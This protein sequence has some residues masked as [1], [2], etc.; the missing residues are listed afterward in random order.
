MRI[1]SAGN[2]LIGTTTDNANKLRV[3]G[4][5]FS[6][7]SVT[8][9]LDSVFNSVNIGRG[10]GSRLSN[11]RVGTTALNDNTTGNDNTAFGYQALSLNTSASQNTALGSMSLQ[12]NTTGSNNTALG[13]IAL[14]SNTTGTTNIAIGSFSLS[15]NT[16]GS[17]NVAIGVISG[18]TN[19][20]INNSILIGYGA[21]A[22]SNNQTNQIVIGH[23]AT[24]NGNHSVTLGNSSIVRTILRG[25]VLVGTTTDSGSRLRIVGATNSS[26]DFGIT[27][28]NLGNDSLFAVR[29]DGVI[30]TGFMASGSP[31]N[32][33]TSSAANMHVDTSG[34]LR[35]STSSLKYKKNVESYEK[36]LNEVMQL[37]PVSYQGKNPADGN[38]NFAG[39]IAEEVHNLGLTEFVQYAKDGSPDALS[40]QNMIALL[41]KAI[42]E[43]KQEIDTLKN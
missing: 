8:A 2:V 9:V 17:E 33:T 38:Q 19:T 3:N 29:D 22:L 18:T 10:G 40:Y 5:I 36:G 24:G 28:N 32:N 34:V 35:R 39:L 15:S 41:T 6:D 30:T 42:Q 37:K 43:L 13:Y 16:T 31:T 25:N 21:T 20:I 12:L 11:T 23:N 7:S 14:Q 26:F 4:T 27:I 1:N